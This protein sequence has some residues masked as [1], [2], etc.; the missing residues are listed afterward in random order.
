MLTYF[1]SLEEVGIYNVVLPTVMI[2]AFFSHAIYHVFFPMVSELWSKNLKDRL[3]QGFYI[4]RQRGSHV[5]LKHIDGRRTTVPMHN[6][7]IGKGL[8]KAILTQT[9]ITRKEFLCY[10]YKKK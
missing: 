4:D 5:F 7:P 10:Y 8:L 1:R 3:R 2:L 9:K 6:F